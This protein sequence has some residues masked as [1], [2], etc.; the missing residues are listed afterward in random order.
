MVKIGEMTKFTGS[1]SLE[2]L[3]LELVSNIKSA[4]T[5]QEY[6]YNCSLKRRIRSVNNDI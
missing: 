4:I 6:M 3:N 2:I 1:K 5:I